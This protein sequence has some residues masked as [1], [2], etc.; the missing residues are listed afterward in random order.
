VDDERDEGFRTF[1]VEFSPVL[2]RAAYLLLRD[3][4]DAEDAVQ[5][6]LLRVLRRWGTAKRAPEAYSQT[7]LLNVCRDHW[8]HN[9]RHPSKSL[10]AS[11]PS[12]PAGW[13]G[14]SDNAPGWRLEAIEHREVLEEALRALP[15]LQR[16]ILVMRF[17]F[18]LPVARTAEMLGVAEGT[19]KSAT[20]RALDHLRTA[21]KPL[22]QEVTKDA[23]LVA[24][25]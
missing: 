18:D 16:E 20:S 23:K 17:F 10:D 15:A 1:V 14:A 11:G 22:Q 25:R 12:G 6:T 13:H 8:K 19:V 2:F 9:R 21:L 7:V 3:R 5:S 24:E 4:R